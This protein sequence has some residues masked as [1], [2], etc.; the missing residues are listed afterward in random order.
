MVERNQ[1]QLSREIFDRKKL[2]FKER[3]EIEE[4]ERERGVLVRQLTAL[5]RDFKS[6]NE[7]LF[8]KE[9]EIVSY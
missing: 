1:E 3:D 6:Y 5:E 8:K 9:K 4:L 7:K 2:S